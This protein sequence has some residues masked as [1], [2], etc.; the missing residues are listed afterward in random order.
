MT[1][2]GGVPLLRR[3]GV[4]PMAS[5][6]ALLGAVMLGAVAA[7]AAEPAGGAAAGV[8][9]PREIPQG[10]LAIGHVFALD[11]THVATVAQEVLLRRGRRVP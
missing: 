1:P 8:D 10:G 5:L 7:G 6:T 2:A 11:G 3:G 9:L 4:A